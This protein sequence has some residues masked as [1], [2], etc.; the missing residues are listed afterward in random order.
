MKDLHEARK[1]HNNFIKAM[2]ANQQE[3]KNWK[4]KMKQYHDDMTN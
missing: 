3:G 2:K 4:K 1:N